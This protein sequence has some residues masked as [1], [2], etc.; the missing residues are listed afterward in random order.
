MGIKTRI[1][2]KK[3]VRVR[4]MLRVRSGIGFGIRTGIELE[5]RVS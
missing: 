1:S 3:R 5:M 2:I 4:N